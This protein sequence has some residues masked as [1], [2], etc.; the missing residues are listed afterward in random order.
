[1]YLTY[2]YTHEHRSGSFFSA[3]FLKN[4]SRKLCVNFLVNLF[5]RRLPRITVPRE[6]CPLWVLPP[7][8]S[9]PVKITPRNFL[10]RKLP[11]MKI[12]PH[13]VPSPLINHTN[14]RKNK[15][16][17]FFALKKAKNNQG[18]LWHTDDLTEITGLWYFL[19]RMKKI[20]KSNKS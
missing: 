1:M 14:E 19:Y 5:Q 4:K 3:Y 2:L 9:P 7:M 6:N 15:I 20:R 10:P 8:K 12:P 13:K 17:K 16:T 11:P 18:P